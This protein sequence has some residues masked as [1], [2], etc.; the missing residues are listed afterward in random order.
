MPN[1][2]D[3]LIVQNWVRWYLARGVDELTVSGSSARVLRMVAAPHGTIRA[4]EVARVARFATPGP[5]ERNFYSCIEAG[6]RHISDPSNDHTPLSREFLDA[7][8]IHLHGGGYLNSKWPTH[9]FLLGLVWG[10]KQRT[11]A[12]AVGTGLGWGPLDAPEGPGRVML[13]DAL[14]SL[15]FMEVRD[16]WSYDFLSDVAPRASVINGLDDAFLQPVNAIRRAGSALHLSLHSNES[17]DDVISQLS[18]GYVGA[19]DSLYFWMCTAGDAGAYGSLAKK[20]PSVLPL[21]WAGLLDGIPLHETNVMITARFH[22]HLVGARLGMTGLYQSGSGYYDVKHGSL[23][24]LG[25]PFTAGNVGDLVEANAGAAGAPSKLFL[26]D[27]DLVAQKAEVAE[28]IL[29]QVSAKRRPADR[30]ARAKTQNAARFFWS[31]R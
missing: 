5:E 21:S 19:F 18:R 29:P 15:D 30:L 27:V 17:A 22:P 26:D 9:A 12:V 10:A 20:F 14:E 25:S 7:E 11:H 16:D 8:I 2:G 24:A 3:E 28:R 6:F 13:R 31:K 4:S 23:L 1:Y